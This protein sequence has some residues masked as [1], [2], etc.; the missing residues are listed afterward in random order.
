M[1]ALAD[2]SLTNTSFK[3]AV[4]GL[5][6]CMLASALAGCD[7]PEL[8]IGAKQFTESVV[9]A[10]LC[11]NL[12]ATQGVEA[13]P[14][15]MIGDTR[16]VWEALLAGDIDVYVDY[17]GTIREETLAG[18]HL[19][20]DAELAAALKRRGV[21]MSRPL[22]FNDTYALGM[23]ETVAEERGIRSISDLR[24][25]PDL[26]FGFS[27]A[28]IDRAD[29]W[30]NVRSQYR[31]P[32][33]RGAVKAMKHSVAYDALATHSIQVL[34]LY[35]T[36]P[37]IEE[38]RLRT[39]ADDLNI[40][41]K[42]DAVLLYRADLAKRHPRAVEALLRLQGQISEAEMIE[43]NRQVK[44]DH[45]PATAVAA[46]FLARKFPE[47]ATRF[48][49]LGQGRDESRAARIWRY[50]KAHL[51]LVSVSLAA[52]VLVA[53]PLGVVA[54]KA[55]RLGQVVLA[56]VGIIQ[57][58]PSLALL[59]LLMVPLYYIG[60]ST[61]GAAPAIAALFLYSLLPIVRNT[62]TGIHNLPKHIRESAEAIGLTPLDRL[63]LVELPMASPTILAG[64]K[65]SAVINVGFATLGAL[66]GAGGYG[67]PILTGIDQKN[68]ALIL[69]GTLSAATLALVVQGL[70]EL[71]ERALIPKGLRLKAS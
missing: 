35:S 66:I 31:L 43:M 19:A 44:F 59:A 32:Q 51:F 15:R 38:F 70:F 55:P 61:I 2:I 27:S 69:E 14:P 57:T 6:V 25:H 45:A 71:A 50:T 13:P 64:V 54:A 41:P 1:N 68:Y 22:G 42:Y 4:A 65:T 21:L 7:E 62:Y 56:V 23:L 58:I 52:A 47:S 8:R 26:K 60:A 39:L 24:E 49:R 3:S 20:N 17:T 9:L 16:H 48:Q 53:I 28:F 63:R 5:L 18:E 46:S 34:D 29:G 30:P 33:G 40:F 36:D 10:E 12:A 37:E 67:Q 11:W